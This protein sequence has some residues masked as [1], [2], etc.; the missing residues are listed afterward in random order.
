MP[1]V[2]FLPGPITA[3][4]DRGERLIQVARRAGVF[5]RADC[6][7]EHKCGTCRVL[8]APEALAA[9]LLSPPAPEEESLTA[10]QPGAPRSR[11]ACLTRVYGDVTVTIPPESRIT[12][13]DAFKTRS[14]PQKS[15]RPAVSRLILSLDSRSGPESPPPWLLRTRGLLAERL[16]G[17]KLIGPN[18]MDLAD[19]SRQPGAADCRQVTVTLFQGREVIQ[20]R[21]GARPEIYGVALDVGTTSLAVLLCDLASGRVL[22][23]QSLTNPQV[24]YGEDVISRISQVQAD[25]HYLTVLHESLIEGINQLIDHAVRQAG[26]ATDDILDVAAVG[27]PTMMH[28]FLGISP[29][30]LGQAPYLPL[31]YGGEEVSARDL[32]LHVYSKARVHLP[33]L[34]SGYVGSDTLAALLALGRRFVKGTSLLMDIGTNG[35]LVLAQ[36]GVLTA[37][38]CATGPAFEGAQIHC[39]MRAS[40]GAIEW[41]SLDKATGEFSFQVVGGAGQRA[42]GLCGSGIISAVSKLR[43]AGIIQANGAFNRDIRHPSFR[44][45]GACKMPEVVLVPASQSETGREI[46]LQQDDIRALQLGKAALRAGAEILMKQAGVV[47][48]DRIFLAGAFGSNLD[49]RDCLNLGMLPPIAPEKIEFVGNAAG[50]GAMMA[51]LDMDIRRQSLKLADRIRVLDLGSHPDFQQLF[52]RSLKL[53]AK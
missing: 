15:R 13:A 1:H 38:S 39:G 12:A 4:A 25:P 45:A 34:L 50:D 44:S 22:A 30:S 31:F 16:M 43:A 41:V 8:V 14:K 6:G 52:I 51:L 7:G 2:T 24:K 19:F 11:L 35:E 49:P 20:L 46:V 10:P 36:D 37:T 5:I 3:E 32:H 47:Q 40:P 27:N 21:P 26:I 53:S 23:A 9:G 48:L 42:A 33:P 17:K 18:L 29:V 28:F